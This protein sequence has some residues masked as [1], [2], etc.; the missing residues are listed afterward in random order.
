M[1]TKKYHAIIG[2]L[3][4]IFGLICTG[5]SIANYLKPEAK[6]DIESISLASLK[7]CQQEAINS[8]FNVAMAGDELRISP[9]KT[10][11][12][13]NPMPEIY[14]LSIL[15]TKCEN[16]YVES[17]CA[18]EECSQPIELIMKKFKK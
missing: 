11:V 12:L 8:G 16:V 10:E 17:F 5:I 4:I 18:G 15:I 6:V 2:T 7:N 9:K 1:N 14:K 3:L 13:N